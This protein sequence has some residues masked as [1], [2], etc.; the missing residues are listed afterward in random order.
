MSAAAAGAG[1][2]STSRKSAVNGSR[3]PEPAESGVSALSE[4]EPGGVVEDMTTTGGDRTNGTKPREPTADAARYQDSEWFGDV[5]EIEGIEPE[6][7]AWSK[8]AGLAVA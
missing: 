2:P 1:V 3:A 5:R 6:A 4:S 8:E 7:M